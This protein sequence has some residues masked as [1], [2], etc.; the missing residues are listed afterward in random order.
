MMLKLLDCFGVED[1]VMIAVYI[2]H[3]ESHVE[4][5]ILIRSVVDKDWYQASSRRPKSKNVNHIDF[6]PMQE[7]GDNALL[8]LQRWLR[9]RESRDLQYSIDLY[10]KTINT[11]FGWSRQVVKFRIQRQ[12]ANIS[13]ITLQ[14]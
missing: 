13:K 7:P 9:S 14:I 6:F 10:R 3:N 4:R 11:E 5:G 1:F 2:Y 12:V 8:Q